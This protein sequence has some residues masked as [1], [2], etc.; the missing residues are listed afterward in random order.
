MNFLEALKSG[1]SFKRESWG[2]DAP[3]VKLYEVLSS[4]YDGK[5][6][7]YLSNTHYGSQ[8][9]IVH[10]EYCHLTILDI[11]AEDWIVKEEKEEEIALNPCPFCGE[12]VELKCDESYKKTPRTLK[13]LIKCK[14]K[15]CSVRYFV[16]D[17]D[18]IGYLNAENISNNLKIFVGKWN[19]RVGRVRND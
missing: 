19:N 14:T 8:G 15:D 11:L 7:V 10:E 6:Y 5:I 1:K 4:K 18:F 9:E 12:E 2:Y 16:N 17:G 13:Y 3:F